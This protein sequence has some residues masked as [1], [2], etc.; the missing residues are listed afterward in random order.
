ME[1]T[2]LAHSAP[3]PDLA[4]QAYADHVAAVTRGARRR[5]EETV[6][7][8]RDPELAEQFVEAVVAAAAFHD[9]GKLDNDMQL[10]LRSGPDAKPN[11][12]HIDAGVSHLMACGLSNS[13]WLVRGHHAPGLPAHAAHFS[14]GA[15][16]WRL[17]GGRHDNA[18]LQDRRAQ[19]ERT[20]K[21]LQ[22]WVDRHVRACGEVDLPTQAAAIHGLALRFMLACHVDADYADTAAFLRGWQ[23]PLV[24][25]PRWEE[26]LAALDVYVAGLHDRGGERDKQRRDF[27]ALCRH[28]FPVDEPLAACEGPV[29]IG[30]TTAVTAWLLRRA[31]ATGARRLFVVAPYTNILTQA[32]KTLRKALTLPG[33][34]PEAVVAEHHH[35]ADFTDA[36]SRDLAT[37]WNAPVVLTTAVQFFETLASNHPGR[38]RKLHALPGSVIFLDEAHAALP[39][40]LWAQN[41]RW[42][43]ELVADWGCSAVL[44]SGSLARFWEI[45]EVVGAERLAALPVLGDDVQTC[46]QR[47]LERARVAFASL[48]LLETPAEL[49]ARV[50]AAPGPRLLIMNT[51]QSAAVMAKLM[52]EQGHD[53]LHLSN[54]LSPRDRANV[55]GQVQDRLRDAAGTDWTLVATSLVEAGVNLSFRTG[56]RERFSTASLLQIA[57]R[58]NRHSEFAGPCTVYDFQLRTTGDLVAHP[59]AGRS[60]QVLGDLLEEGCFC[61]EEMDAAALESEALRREL[62]PS[63][64]LH[65]DKQAMLDAEAHKDYP[66]VAKLGRVIDDETVL[67]VVDSALRARLEAREPITP[68]DLLMGSVRM[69]ENKLRSYGLEE[70]GGRREI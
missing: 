66:A 22:R 39:A 28:E 43:Q 42:L 36:S 56:F 64:T 52:R 40:P 27:Y 26:R 18:D 9:L 7:Y 41:W 62:W 35:R 48:G 24:L 8:C 65:H 55:L 23:E 49:M 29:G 2:L 32:A 17:R 16:D 33:E 6:A 11:W 53:V 57:G 47:A 60:G 31:I 46:Q 5:A 50:V 59:L 58:V 1:Q 20:D 10:V 63:T 4:P 45:P 69:R 21:Y 34:S 68:H 15:N 25:A 19:Q 54:A 61:Q 12:D 13:A 51:V 38:L 3:R 14:G 70:I 44:A 67:V 30:K 37:L